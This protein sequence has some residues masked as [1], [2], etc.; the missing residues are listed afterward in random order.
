MPRPGF[1]PLALVAAF[2]PAAAGQG[3]P[4]TRADLKPGL[5][6]TAVDAAGG[7]VVVSR[8]DPAVGLTLAAGESPHPRS[9]GGQTFRWHG[10]LNVL[11]PGKYQ[12]SA[13]VLGRFDVT[14]G[15]TRVLAGAATGADPATDAAR[16]EGPVV[17][18]AA[19]LLP[20]EATLARTGPGA[21]AELL[22]RGPQ[23]QP[24][25]VPY[26]ALGHLPRQRPDTF[27]ADAARDHGRFLFEEL[28]CGK[29]HRP[30]AADKPAGLVDRT[31]PDLSEVGKR[32][33]PGWLDAWLAAPHRLRPHTAMPEMFAAD[34]AGRAERY[35]VARYLASLGGPPADPPADFKEVLK[36]VEAG[37]KLYLTTGCAACHG[38]KLTGPPTA[39][40][41]KDD[42]DDPPPAL[43]PEDSFYAA[44]T[45]GPKA[46]YQ[47]GAV[48][49]KY[50]VPALTAYLKN[51]LA[52]NPHGRMPNM[53]LADQEASD[54]AKYLCRQVDE[55]VPKGL[56]AGP[57]GKSDAEWQALGKSL[58][59]SKACVNCHAV[60]PGG[61]PL[62][63]ATTPPSL[64]A[65]RK[66][67]DGRGCLSPTPAAGKVPV[68]HLDAGQRAALGA[69]LL[70]G[71]GTR[72]APAHAARL[73]VVLRFGCLACHNRDGEGGLDEPLVDLMKEGS[74]RPRTPTTS[75]RPGSPASATNSWPRTSGGCSPRRSGPARG[76]PCG[77]R[78]T[79]PTTSASWWTPCP[80]SKERSPRRRPGSPISPPPGSRP[81]ANWPAR[82]GSGAWPATTSPGWP[83]G[84]PAA[85]T[86]RRPPGGSAGTGT[87]GGC[88]SPS[89]SPPA[90]GCRRT[91]GEGEKGKGGE[92][93]KK[94]PAPALT[95]GDADAQIEALWSY[96]SLGPGL[97]LP[98]GTEP[99]GKALVVAVG[100]RPVLLRTFMPDGAGTKAVAVGYPGGVSLVF[101]AATCRLGYAWTG[102]FLDANPVWA[103]RGGAPA[104]LL[105]PKFWQAPVGH[106]WAVTGSRT[107]PDFGAR[108]TDPAYGFQLKDDEFYGYDPRTDPPTQE[109]LGTWEKGG[110]HAGRRYVH[111]TGYRLDPAGRPAF[112][113]RLDAPD[114]GPGL[115][116][117]ER[118]GP[119]PI[120]AAAG[121]SR[122]FSVDVAGGQ[123]AWF[124]AA[125][126]AKEPRVYAADGTVRPPG[127]TGGPVDVAAAGLRVV[128]PQD[129]DTATVLDVTAAPPGTAWHFAPKPGGRWAVLLRLPEAAGKAGVV[130][131]VWG[132]PRDDERLLSGLRR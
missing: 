69:F 26:Y 131:N 13:T 114:G 43:K 48:G 94:N 35:A 103:N 15:G 29:C 67:G 128:A 127:G 109:R 54:L 74:K 8:L 39:R 75:S 57:V 100:D 21:R 102:N 6:F 58:L 22:W 108:A 52:T 106:P 107:A 129:G 80:S 117:E 72:P 98:P 63:A 92:G 96:L 79:G 38:D 2:A 76:S 32:V 37:R 125:D 45:A 50:T 113:Y 34:E 16:V 84:A 51:P 42:E 119:L 3:Q 88:T 118:P 81:A 90:P 82:P 71:P 55:A 122:S 17:D 4:L 27:S 24:E 64:A 111:F 53:V 9:A 11:Q 49:S 36:S 10:F 99:P 1:L 123:T 87:G 28:S 61:K 40:K 120:A 89:G 91:S 101:D 97:P 56:P 25:P 105:G 47:L 44:G 30:D 77:C 62:Q 124:H 46:V 70:D 19:G 132:L 83:A 20:L 112:R 104:K 95:P 68:Y 85:R 33:R 41:P 14:V 23:F 78:N 86:W 115:T 18:L 5:V 31:G 7:P 65:V 130:L 73:A 121:L 126:A 12:F 66:A 110:Y 59:T 60:A 93:E 116:V